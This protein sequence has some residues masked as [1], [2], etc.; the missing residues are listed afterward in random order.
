MNDMDYTDKPTQVRE[1]ETL[2]E[3]SLLAYLNQQLD[4]NA[5]SLEVLQFPGG[6]SNL[7]YQITINQ[8]NYILRRPPIGTKAKSA[9]DMGREFTVLNELKP[10]F[11]KAPEA[12]LFCDDLSVIGS[13]FYLMKALEG[14]IFRKN[15]PKGMRISASQAKQLCHDMVKTLVDL[16]SIEIGKTPLAELGRMDGYVE[17]QVEGWAKRYRNAKTDDVP[18]GENVIEWLQA[19][20]PE[21]YHKPTLIHNDYKFDNLVL[22]EHDDSLD[23]IGVL[24]WEMTTLGHPLMDLG[25]SLAYWVE[26]TDAPQM[27]A[28]RTMPTQIDGMM[29]RDEIVKLYSELSGVDIEDFTYY[30]VFGLFRLAGIVQQIYYRFYHGQTKDKRFAQFGQVCGILLAKAQEEINNYQRKHQTQE[31]GA[32]PMLNFKDK[33]ALISGASRGIGE[34]TAKLIAQNG[35]HVILTSRSKDSLE[36]VAQDISDAGGKVSVM[37]CHI[38]EPAAI[39][40]L[41]SDIQAQFGKLDIL[42]NNAAT[43]PYFGHV[44]DMPVDAFD[45]TI[46]VNIKGYFLMSQKAGQLMKNNGGGAMVNIASV[47]GKTPAPMQAVYS[48]TKSAVISMTQAFAKECA[49]FNIRVNAVLPG[50]TDTKFASALTQ[51]E[52]ML[53]MILPLIPMGRMA[54]PEEI[55]PSIAFLVSDA[56]SYVTGTC[57]S[58]DGGYLS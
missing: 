2:D 47:N 23:I 57:L 37:P 7:T 9:H 39:D 17:R 3:A 55:A 14:I 10:Y 54:Q 13:E 52:Q 18:N 31:S 41:F 16:H 44:L 29:K 22:A 49:A 12:I 32:N 35:A 33:V 20:M 43:N 6:N 1:D 19:H 4:L 50:L 5:S 45:K 8:Q 25:S 40:K 56:A 11:D 30:Y 51:N 42:I 36:K 28:L 46:D 58:V 26:A 21:D 34:A 24:D 38:G 27:H 53:K 15:P 48:M